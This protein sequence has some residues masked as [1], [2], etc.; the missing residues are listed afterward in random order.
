MSSSVV[1]TPP[2]TRRGR[3]AIRARTLRRDAWWVPPAITVAVLLAFIAYSTFRAFH[4]DYY[5]TEPY[6]SP[7]YSPCL[8]TGCAESGAPHLGLFREFWLITPAVYI[9]LFPL[10]FR[11]TC[12]YYRKA[13]YRSF[14][15]SP[16]ACAV[17]EPHKRYTG[18]TRFPLVLQ[19]FHRYFF[20][21]GVVFAAILT[22][23][24]LIAFNFDGAFG[25]GLGTLILLVNAALIWAYTLS[26]HSCRH[27]V[28]GRINT[29]SKHPIRY[30]MW[31]FV[32]WLN[33]KHM[34]WAWVSLVWIAFA[35]LYIW[36]VAADVISDPHWTV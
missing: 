25:V 10:G 6:L 11:L 20:Y 2:Q 34:Q 22:W 3:A 31:G 32:T 1:T 29:F 14:W 30:R 33:A 12:Y 13:Y 28:G 24:A 19:N 36:L 5:F 35:D 8:S 16:P 27:L 23:D 4:N 9:L 18:E 7:F 17:A 21:F 26:C 15:L